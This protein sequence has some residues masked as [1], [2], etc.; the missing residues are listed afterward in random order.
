[1]NI[2]QTRYIYKREAHPWMMHKVK[3]QTMASNPR[4]SFVQAWPQNT[5]AK[6]GVA[7][8]MPRQ[9]VKKKGD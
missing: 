4:C 9:H 3:N 1:M 6:I 8:A 7:S 5:R 2:P